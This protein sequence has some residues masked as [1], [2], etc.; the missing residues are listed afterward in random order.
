MRKTILKVEMRPGEDFQTFALR[1]YK[2][3]VN[4]N[5]FSRTPIDVKV[6][7]TEGIARFYFKERPK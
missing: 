7:R 5:I 3:R 4:L 6:N 2:L 1:V